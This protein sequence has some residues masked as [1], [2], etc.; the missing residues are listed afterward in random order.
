MEKTSPERIFEKSPKLKEV[1]ENLIKTQKGLEKEKLPPLEKEKKIKEEIKRYLK[2]LQKTPSFAPPPSSYDE[3]KEIE[4]LEPSQQVGA[5]VNLV[6]EEGLE[7]A[8]SLARKLNN[9]AVLDEFHDV[10]VDN[11]YNFLVE[12]KIIKP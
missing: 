2:E 1:T 12:K 3:L 8:I 4:D 11:Y 5:L 7:K 9:P 10:L 6:F